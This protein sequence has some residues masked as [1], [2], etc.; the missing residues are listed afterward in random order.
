MC[1]KKIANT[2]DVASKVCAV[3]TAPAIVFSTAATVVLFPVTIFFSLLAGNL[4]ERLNFILSNP[5]VFILLIFCS[6]FLIGVTYSSAS[7]SDIF[8]VLRKY[9]KYL[10][11]VMFFPLFREEK[12]RNYAINAFLASILVL[13]L[14]SYLKHF[15]WLRQWSTGPVEIFRFTIEFNFLMAF[16]AYL[17]LFKFVSIRSHWRWLWVAFFLLV[18]HTVL[19]RSV[20]RSGYIVFAGLM[21]LFFLQRFRWKGLVIAATSMI[22]LFSAV[23]IF[24]H[25]F[26]HRMELVF[27]DI[28]TYHKD[29]YTSVGLRITFVKNSLKLIKSNPVFGTGTGSFAKEYREIKPTP[30]IKSTNPHNEYMYVMVQFGF[31]GLVMLLLFFGV[32]WRYSRFLPAQE[33]YIAQGIIISIMLGSLANSWLLDVTEGHCYAYFIAL[34]FG[35]L[36]FRRGKFQIEK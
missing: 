12:W 26:K 10:F 15:S 20:G 1:Y 13:L 21:M 32:P 3:L 16:G 33:K 29:D 4:R 9:D 24:S 5:V 23:Y 17:C 30:K 18:I 27:K 22:L 25:P 11:A 36:S 6:M 7:W 35:A 19:F 2:F 31:V 28:K 8:L 34:A 14:A